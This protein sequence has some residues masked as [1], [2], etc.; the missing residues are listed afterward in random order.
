MVAIKCIDRAALKGKEDS[1]DNE[2]KVLH[3]LKHPN[4]VRLV[5][6]FEDR[7]KVYLVM[8]L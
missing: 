3:K 4:I 6:T 8:E 1:L 5:E 7:A 2:I